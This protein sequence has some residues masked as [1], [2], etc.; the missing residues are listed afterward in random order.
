MYS[1]SAGNS[2]LVDS[3]SIDIEDKNALPAVAMMVVDKDGKELDPQPTSVPEG[4]SVMVAVMVVDKDGD[5]IEAAED[6]TVAL[7]PTGTADSGTTFW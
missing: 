4:E 5:V 7:M 2:T 6:L 3:L 1:G